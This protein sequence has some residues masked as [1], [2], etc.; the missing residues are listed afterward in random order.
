MESSPCIAMSECLIRTAPLTSLLHATRHRARDD[1]EPEA[2]FGR[3]V[4]CP[5][6]VAPGGPAAWDHVELRSRSAIL[7]PAV[8]RDARTGRGSERPGLRRLASAGARPRFDVPVVLIVDDSEDNRELFAMCLE[9]LGCRIEL[10]ID[11][12]DGLE[13]ARTTLPDVVLMDLAMP[14]MDGFAA[15]RHMRLDPELSSVHIIAVTAFSD[16][17]STER[18]LAA[19]CNAVLAKPCPPDVLCAYVEQA[20]DSAGVR[21]CDAG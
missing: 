14:K 9:R 10:A 19:G 8:E 13:R 1:E 17:V 7:S 16:D 21:A 18:A 6:H 15:T 5:A 11:G 2:L 4:D 20:L 12:V 3:G